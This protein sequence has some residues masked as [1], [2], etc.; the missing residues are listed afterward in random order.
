[1]PDLH[2][3]V[4]IP[5][6]NEAATIGSVV[7]AVPRSLVR[8]IVVVDNGSTDG[9]AAVARA[10]GAVVTRETR[11]GYGAACLAGV[12]RLPPGSGIVVFLDGD[13]SDD[14]S[15][16]SELVAPIVVGQADLVVG[17]RTSRRAHREVLTPAQRVGNALASA[18][19]R[20]RFSLPA[21]D[22]GPFRAIRRS[23]LQSLRMSDRGY[24]WTVEMQIKAA[25]SGLRYL[26]VPVP[27]RPRLAGRSKVSGTI[28][29]TLGAATKIVGLLARHDLLAR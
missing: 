6:L 11:R 27:C 2:I 15:L 5:A 29:G 16:I 18:W 17:T 8:S 3:D 23:S 20:R 24:G 26:E 1:M 10:A 22:L 13:G 12:A 9:T 7:R 4:V 14:A 21:T 25:R 19:L 28:S